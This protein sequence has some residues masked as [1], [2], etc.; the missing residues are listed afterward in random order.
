MER[1][2]EHTTAIGPHPSRKR[3]SVVFSPGGGDANPGST[4]APRPSASGYRLAGGPTSCDDSRSA[5]RATCGRDAYQRGGVM[6]RDR[7]AIDVQ[8]EPFPGDLLPIDAILRRPASAF[9]KPVC[10]LGLAS[11]GGSG[12]TAGRRPPCPRARGQ[13]P[14]LAGRPRTPSAGRSPS[15]GRAASGWSSAPSSRPAPPPTRPRSCGR[16]STALGTDYIDV[17]TFYY[18]EEPGEWDQLSGPGGALDYCRA[19][20]RDGLVRRLG[21]TTH[22]R[23]PGRRGRPQRPA[24]R[25]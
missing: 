25:C 23:R 9:G 2:P 12:L 20:R 4:P 15:S 7:P 5:T 6:E 1:L 17:L 8:D 21:L 11:R 14:Q 16:C 22:Q 3:A 19:A 13:L 18:V 10:R 24:R